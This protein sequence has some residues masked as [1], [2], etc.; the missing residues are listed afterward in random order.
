MTTVLKRIAISEENYRK[1]EKLGGFGDSFNDVIGR[2]LEG[3]KK[4]EKGGSI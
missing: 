2:L 4:K 1:L 3:A